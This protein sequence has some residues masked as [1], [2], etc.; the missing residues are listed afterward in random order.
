MYSLIFSSDCNYVQW[1]NTDQI[2]LVE[3]LMR[4]I[5]VFCTMMSYMIAHDVIYIYIDIYIYT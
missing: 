3:G 1:S 2:I 4:N 5:C